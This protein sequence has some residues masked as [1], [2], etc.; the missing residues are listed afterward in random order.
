MTMDRA[1]KVLAERF[2]SRSKAANELIR[3]RVLKNGK[4]LKPSDLIANSEGLEFRKERSFVSMGGY[5]L[6]RLF[7]TCPISLDGKV[8]ADIGASTGGFTDCM[9]QHGAKKVYAVD[10]GENLLDQSLQN[11]PCV[12]AMDHQNARYLTKE[13]FPEPIQA[14]S[15]DVS[16]IS[17][18]LILPVLSSLTD[19]NGEIYALIKPQFESGSI[20]KSGILKDSKKRSEIVF[21]ILSTAKELG[22]YPH[23]FINAPIVEKKNVEYMVWWKKTPIGSLTN[24]QIETASNFLQ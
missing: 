20:G 12:V 4:P 23:G 24:E 5:K 11:N 7:S 21:G 2:G 3:G 8:A 9:L 14:I 13:Q 19:E 18:K 22:W 15:I 1:D 16:F 17:I 10:V 6:E